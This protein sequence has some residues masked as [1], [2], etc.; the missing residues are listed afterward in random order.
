MA[1]SAGGR[2]FALEYDM[3]RKM[4]QLLLRFRWPVILSLVV[5]LVLFL[6]CEPRP[7]TVRLIKT[8]GI[9][10]SE[11]YFVSPSGRYL[12]F[13]DYSNHR[14]TYYDLQFK[15]KV[16]ELNEIT[17]VETG[18]DNEDGLSLSTVNN[19]YP[20][21]WVGW[22]CGAGGEL[23]KI[24]TSNIDDRTKERSYPKGVLLSADGRTW[25]KWS[26]TRE[27][28]DEIELLDA[29]KGTIRAMLEYQP[30][31]AKGSKGT[32][33]PYLSSDSRRIVIISQKNIFDPEKESW[34]DFYDMDTGH[35][36]PP[37]GYLE[38]GYTEAITFDGQKVVG[39]IERDGCFY[40]QSYSVVH[41][42]HEWKLAEVSSKLS[43]KQQSELRNRF[44]SKLMKPIPID[45]DVVLVSEYSDG[46]SIPL[47][48]VRCDSDSRPNVFAWKMVNTD[49]LQR[50]DEQT[51][52]A[53]FQCNRIGMIGVLPSFKL[54]LLCGSKD[55][56]EWLVSLDAWIHSHAS[57]LPRIV[58]YQQK[59]KVYDPIADKQGETLTLPNVRGTLW[60]HPKQQAIYVVETQDSEL[61]LH[62]YAYPFQRSWKL[63]FSWAGY[64]FLALV[65]LQLLGLGWKWMISNG[66]KASHYV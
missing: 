40:L 19:D 53:S 49:R 51:D 11:R 33:S 14:L 3:L 12:L 48:Y 61:I 4:G 65:L 57:W 37:S 63:I 28:K 22:F 54:L 17:H 9:S 29:K 52:L 10:L 56:P 27:G 62:K 21:N 35:H 6:T 18:F 25:L 41:G 44:R 42:K 60:Y 26:V 13:F 15:N 24:F 46:Q 31:I 32:V 47:R 66:S 45:S 7:E 30:R 50:I 5:G 64:V 20:R 2:L 38:H 8:S 43:E 55:P 39:V 36:M 23:Q 58:S 1:G 16:F 34:I 59:L